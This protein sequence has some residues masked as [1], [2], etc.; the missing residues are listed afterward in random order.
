MAKDSK[1]PYFYRQ[2]KLD[3]VFGVFFFLCFVFIVWATLDD[4]GR[5]W[6]ETQR[7]FK[8]LMTDRL[9]G[10]IGA[11]A[12][13]TD[14][15]ALAATEQRIA[16]E[17]AKIT[18]QHDEIDAVDRQIAE[19]DT[20]LEALGLD[21]GISEAILASLQYEYELAQHERS[22]RA[23]DLGREFTEQETH[24]RELKERRKEHQQER[25]Q[26]LAERKGMLAR[27]EDARKARD[28]MQAE[29]T[30]L[31]SVLGKYESA[32]VDAVLD[33]PLLDFIQPTVQIEQIVVTDVREDLKFVDV[34]TVDRCITCHRGIARTGF[35]EE[36]AP[37]QSHPRL[38]LFVG[39]GS[40][41]PVDR[42]GCTVCHGG[43]GRSLSFSGAAHTPRDKQ[44]EEEWVE[45]YDWHELHHFDYPM[46]PLGHVESS[47][48]KCHDGVRSVPEATTLNRGRETFFR[49]GCYGCHETRGFNDLP[50]LGPEL[51]AIASK[52]DPLWV[53]NWVLDPRALRPTTVMPQFLGQSNQVSEE[54]DHLE[55]TAM[56]TYLFEHSRVDDYP[57][58]PPGD[59]ARGQE[60]FETVGCRGCH[61]VGGEE[62]TFGPNLQNIGGKTSPGWI[63]T[64]IRDPRSYSEI[65][66][67]PNLRLS[68]EEAANITAYLLTLRGEPLPFD[69]I[70][71][72][73]ETAID[74]ALVEFL[75]ARR[76]V[77]DARAEIAEWSREKKL[78]Q[79]GRSLIGRYGCFGCHEIEEFRDY[80]KIG[81]SLSQEGSKP[82]TRLDFGFLGHELGET[83]EAFFRQKMKEPRAFDRDRVRKPL[84]RLRMPNFV[85]DDEE[86]E[87]L[88][89]HLLSLTD[90]EMPESIRRSLS[91]D[92]TLVQE[93]EWLVAV[94]NCRGC[95]SI[96]GEGGEIL[97]YYEDPALGPPQ[98]I[99]EGR[100]LQAVWLNNFLRRPVT[101]RPWLK[102]RMPSFGLGD[103]T[104]H[105]IID[106]F[107]AKARETRRI[108]Y[109]DPALIASEAYHAGS[110][111]F[112]LLKC[113][114]CHPTGSEVPEGSPDNWGPD[115]AMAHKR[116]KPHW[117]IDWLRN[118]QAVQPGTKMPNFFFDYDPEYD[119]WEELLPDAERR[120]Y[121]VRDYLMTM[122]REHASR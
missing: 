88:T 101:L 53:F 42:F 17:E 102:V 34:P 103:E 116:L 51:N 9:N 16:E 54:R 49:H 112:E 97:R 20:K 36:A 63:Y 93:G 108:A 57:A 40:P 58:P 73:E 120:M 32:P 25:E 79:L 5:E 44:Q 13:A 87:A 29:R 52:T 14:S 60:L 39:D 37:F 2:R 115:L 12:A 98:L 62:S 45:R 30:R 86:V 10:E 31:L 119:E 107:E 72:V 46:H 121:N 27:L 19:L 26:L 94:Q 6:K 122:N 55:A 85:F 35:E 8:R 28:D 80:P 23:E 68:E 24:F 15:T 91:I 47:C 92:E 104:Q 82:V 64:W 113:G 90:D 111:T 114:S 50:K 43:R 69:E 67:M 99:N 106:Y 33:A 74:E 70:P 117:V 83:R 84:D 56:A 100:K 89:T 75:A 48:L 22:P 41:H 110:E 21:Y 109:Y 65:A 105:V 7:S 11:L 81:T 61:A 4:H 95:H 71:P 77:A 18:E 118:P 38:D 59:A 1:A 78:T 76:P 3:L 66:R 96:D